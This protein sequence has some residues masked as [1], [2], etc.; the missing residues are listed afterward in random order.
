[1]I[2]QGKHISLICDLHEAMQHKWSGKIFFLEDDS[3]EVEGYIEKVTLKG[4]LLFTEKILPEKLPLQEGK[5][6]LSDYVGL[7]EI[8]LSNLYYLYKT[9][10]KNSPFVL[11]YPFSE[12]R[13]ELFDKL[14]SLHEHSQIELNSLVKLYSSQG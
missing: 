11:N 8:I 7:K 13:A 9:V 3:M 4:E 1:M 6:V 12:Q 5:K 10:N 2:G 14:L